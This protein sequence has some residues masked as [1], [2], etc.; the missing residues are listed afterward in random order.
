[1]FQGLEFPLRRC[2]L[3]VKTS[4]RTAR[5]GTGPAQQ[6]LDPIRVYPCS[7]A[8]PAS[9]K[10]PPSLKLWRTRRRTSKKPCGARRPRRG[11]PYPKPA[12]PAVTPYQTARP[13]VAPCPMFQGLEERQ[14]IIKP[15][16][17]QAR[18]ERLSGTKRSRLKPVCGGGNR[19]GRHRHQTP[20]PR[21]TG[22][23]L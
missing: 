11:L 19:P 20:P 10:L 13:A 8:V 4:I 18:A 22:G 16:L 1:M 9:L 6:P 23:P 2:V 21:Q 17:L 7:S 12:R 15:K 5:S 14:T 3:A